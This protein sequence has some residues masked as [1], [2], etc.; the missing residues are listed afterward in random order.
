MRR[1]DN[2]SRRTV[3]TEIGTFQEMWE[4][5]RPSN[6]SLIMDRDRWTSQVV[7][8]GARVP[9]VPPC[10]RVD[11]ERLPD[12]ALIRIEPL[13]RGDR[14][15]VRG[16]FARLSAESRLRRFLS[17]VPALSERELTFLS[18]VG[19]VT[20][21]AM[22]AVDPDD[23]S[24]AGIARYV[25][26]QGRPGVADVAVAV[27]DEMQRRGIGTVL[28]DRLITCAQANGFHLLT[29]TTLWENRAARALLRTMGFQATGSD[30]AEIEL[31]LRL[32]VAPAPGPPVPGG[33][34]A[35]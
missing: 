34:L 19:H 9:V 21:E 17:P 11:T 33:L 7:D 13:K 5:L 2:D 18:D 15:S 24:I 10:A 26:Y 25:Q 29:A 22:T 4:E 3:F 23:G 14:A 35:C 30:G 32:D 27:A 16:L 31:A 6:V 8:G 1:S 20:H 28:M 12:G